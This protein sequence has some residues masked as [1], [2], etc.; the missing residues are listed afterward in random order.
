[1]VLRGSSGSK[2]H[3][4]LYNSKSRNNLTGS[5]T[6]GSLHTYHERPENSY[7]Y[8]AGNSDLNQ[9]KSLIDIKTVSKFNHNLNPNIG[10]K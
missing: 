7:F 3:D 6:A 5:N 2:K 8:E 10:K 9:N 1:M 4:S